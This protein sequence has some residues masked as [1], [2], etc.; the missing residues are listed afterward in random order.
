MLSSGGLTAAKYL[1]ALQR[2]NEQ[3]IKIADILKKTKEPEENGLKKEDKKKLYEE[4]EFLEE[5]REEIKEKE[6]IKEVKEEEIIELEKEEKEVLEIEE[7][8]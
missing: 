6:G 5:R 2:G 4:F 8:V 3:L 7:L 1:E